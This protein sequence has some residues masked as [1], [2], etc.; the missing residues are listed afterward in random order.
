MNLIRLSEIDSSL[1]DLV[2]SKAARLGEMT[3]AG[4]RVPDGFCLTVEAYRSRHLLES[5]LIDAYEQLGGGKVA[6]RSSTT[7]EDLPDASFAGQQDTYLDVEGADQLV[8]A[9]LRCWDSLHSERAV[10]YRAAVGID[11][12]RNR[13]RTTEGAAEVIGGAP[14]LP[15]VG[16]LPL[17]Q[18]LPVRTLIPTIL[19]A[20]RLL[21]SAR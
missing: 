3:K 11:D 17:R 5:E 7:A 19:H 20:S 12:A 6:V 18:R 10:S 21:T 4:E 15:L 16:L 9:V 1:L 2:G 13:P 8:D 14:A